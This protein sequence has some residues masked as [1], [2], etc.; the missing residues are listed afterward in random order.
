MEPGQNA[1]IKGELL[2]SN[3]TMAQSE[4]GQIVKKATRARG[5]WGGRWLGG[6]VRHRGV[7]GREGALWGCSE[8]RLS[9]YLCSNP[10]MHTPRVTLMSAVGFGWLD[11]SVWVRQ[12]SHV[13]PLVWDVDREAVGGGGGQRVWGLCL[14]LHFATYLKLL[15][16]IKSI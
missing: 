6:A 9:L 5:W 12:L 16:K 14:P 8:G 4:D 10:R 3:L 15:Y 11:G 2:I 7:Q 1:F 13:D